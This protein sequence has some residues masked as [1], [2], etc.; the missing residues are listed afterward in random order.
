MISKLILLLSLVLGQGMLLKGQSDSVERINQI[1]RHIEAD[2]SLTVWEFDTNEV[3]DQVSDG[4]GVITLWFDS[5][6]IKEIYQEIYVSFGRISTVI[7]FDQGKPVKIIE[8]EANFKWREDDTGWDYSE[9]KQVFQADI[10]IFDWDKEQFSVNVEGK[11]LMAKECCL[12][13]DYSRLIE[14]GRELVKK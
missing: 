5:M 8:Q 11:R 10:Y 1:T 9:I 4:G 2:T 7:Y 12:L 3:Y 13:S 14:L 6:G